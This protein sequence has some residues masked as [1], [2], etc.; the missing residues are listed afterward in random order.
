MLIQIRRTIQDG[1]PP[2]LLIISSKKLTENT[3]Q[4]QTMVKTWDWEF[5]L[6]AMLDGDLMLHKLTTNGMKA[7]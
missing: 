2:K 3:W 5:L 4:N 7:R 6:R 1:S